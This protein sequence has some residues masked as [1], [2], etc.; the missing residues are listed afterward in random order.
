MDSPLQMAPA[1]LLGAFDLK[2][3]GRNP[4]RFGD[5][6]FPMTDITDFYLAQL[7]QSVGTTN[8]IAIGTTAGASVITVPAA[9]VYRV[10]AISGEIVLGGADAALTATGITYVTPPVGSGAVYLPLTGAFTKVSTSLW[11]PGG[12]IEPLVLTS[13]WRLTVAGNLSGANAATWNLRAAV[14]VQVIPQ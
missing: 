4:D 12:R 5:T 8:T 9:T 14:L 7:L 3:T 10:L 1:G 2:V 13:G 11:L 6:V